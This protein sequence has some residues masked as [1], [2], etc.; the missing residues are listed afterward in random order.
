MQAAVTEF[1]V[2]TLSARDA[3]C[4]SDDLSVVSLDDG[5]TAAQGGQRAD[6]IQ[7]LAA[8]LQSLLSAFELQLYQLPQALCQVAVLQTK[9]FQFCRRLMVLQTG[10]QVLQLQPLLFEALADSPLQ[11]LFQFVESLGLLQQTLS[12]VQLL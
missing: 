9:I 1:G 6:R 5:I 4:V 11:A 10:V 7:C 12:R 2:D 3:P 8:C